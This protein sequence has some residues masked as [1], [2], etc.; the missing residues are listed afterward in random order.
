MVL[1]DPLLNFLNLLVGFGGGWSIGEAT[2]AWARSD[3][4]AAVTG[5]ILLLA[6]LGLMCLLTLTLGIQD[7]TAL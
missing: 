1:H 4:R 2:R 6:A 7:R 3:T 5:G